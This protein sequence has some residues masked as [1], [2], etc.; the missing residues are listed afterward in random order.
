MLRDSRWPAL[1]AAGIREVTPI[2]DRGN[3]R[4]GFCATRVRHQLEMLN[5]YALPETQSVGQNNWPAY[6]PSPPYATGGG[7]CPVIK[8]IAPPS[9]YNLPQQG[10]AT[11]RR[12]KR[13]VSFQRY[14][15][16][17]KNAIR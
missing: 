6:C 1:N 2:K 12:T 13:A 7:V 4:G 14:C 9:R 15:R 17:D 5:L 16:A 8:P 3:L 11:V 10:H